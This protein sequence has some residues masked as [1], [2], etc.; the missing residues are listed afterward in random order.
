MMHMKRLLTSIIAIMVMAATL[1]ACTDEKHQHTAEAK[2]TYTCPMHPQIVQE[3]PGTCP[4]C[5]MDLVVFDRTGTDRSLTLSESQVALGD[6]TTMIIG[7]TSLSSFKRLNGRLAINPETT[8]ELS[9]RVAGRIEKLYIKE[10]GVSIVKGQPLYQIYSEQLSALQEEYLLAHAQQQQ[11][12]G[13]K[14]FEN[15]KVAA[16]QKLLLY[17]QTESQLQRL[18]TAGKVDAYVTYFAPSGGIVASI[19]AAE[20]QYIGEGGPVIRIENY[21]Q[22][23]VEAD[24]Y[25]SEASLVKKGQVVDVVMPGQKEPVKKMKI[26][27]INPLLQ[28]GSQL[29]QVRGTIENK[30]G[31]LRPGMQADILLPVSSAEHVLSLPAAAVIRDGSG[32]HA[33]VEVSAN[34]FEPRAVKTGMENATSVEIIEGLESGEKVVKSGAYLLYSEYILKKGAQPG[35]GHQH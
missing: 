29:L 20:G 32:A 21:G 3:K 16:K 34:K 12:P 9:T 13:D 8:V 11:F 17:G 23:W 25:P 33:W 18:L 5:G 27:F 1:T 6:I 28:E 26:A 15:I 35:A 24:V 22:L 14:Q 2:T 30:E 19:L 4:I 7:D 31:R 10:P